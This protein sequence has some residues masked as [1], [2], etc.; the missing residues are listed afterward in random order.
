MD[1]LMSQGRL[2]VLDAGSKHDNINIIVGWVPLPSQAGRGRVAV[3]LIIPVAPTP[4]NILVA[5]CE[6]DHTD[7]QVAQHGEW[8]HAGLHL[9]LRT[10]T[11]TQRGS[12]CPDEGFDDRLGLF[13]EFPLY[14]QRSDNYS[15][16]EDNHKSKENT[17]TGW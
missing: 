12:S 7:A 14:G 5:V 2:L 1:D 3:A 11:N 6:C 10:F 9:F 17:S 4:L 16:R 13:D 15:Q 8:D